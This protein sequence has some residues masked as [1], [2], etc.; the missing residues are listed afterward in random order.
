MS[1]EISGAAL[2]FA[3]PNGGNGPNPLSLSALD[4]SFAVLLF[5]RDHFCG[6]CRKQV[7]AVADRYDE[8][9]QLDAEVISVL[10]EPVERARE[11]AESYDLPFPI[12]ADEDTTV[13]DAYGQPVRFGFLGNLHNLIGRMPEAVIVDLRDE[14]RSMYTYVGT[15]PADRPS[16]DAL[17]AEIAQAAGTV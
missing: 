2:E 11:W 13:S 16:I 1:T 15:A 10:P 7:Q 8:F 5:Q 14:P 17:L 4:A 3:L 6:N 12:I 9:Q